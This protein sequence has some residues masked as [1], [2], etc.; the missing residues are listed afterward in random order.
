MSRE[1]GAEQQAAT[2]TGSE[3]G[4]GPLAA[5]LPSGRARVMSRVQRWPVCWSRKTAG[6]VCSVREELRPDPRPN[7][8][9]GAFSLP[10]ARAPGPSCSGSAPSAGLRLQ[11]GAGA[12]KGSAP[13]APASCARPACAS[14]RVKP[15]QG[16]SRRVEARAALKL[17]G[18][19]SEQE[20]RPQFAHVVGGGWRSPA[21]TL[22][23]RF[24]AGYHS[25]CE[26]LVSC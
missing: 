6:Q 15:S 1:A 12:C 3:G 14:S 2:L 18:K 4:S 20:A 23:A 19:R 11:Q 22:H 10:A 9:L 21:A 24:R 17:S 16:R 5:S 25:A 8:N 13:A 26:M 7:P